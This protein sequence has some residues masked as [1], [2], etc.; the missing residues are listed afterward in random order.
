MEMRNPRKLYERI[1]D[2]ERCEE[3]HLTPN[4]SPEGE[5]NQESGRERIEF[6]LNPKTGKRGK[7]MITTYSPER[8]E[9]VYCE[10]CYEREVVV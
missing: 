1:C 9:R 7:K 4:P 3:N 8:P 2:C 5:G 10:V 6:A